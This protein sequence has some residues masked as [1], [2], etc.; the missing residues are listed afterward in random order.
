MNAPSSPT[1]PPH[2]LVP[3][4]RVPYT[5]SGQG[6]II[7]VPLA[8]VQD[9]GFYPGLG[10]ASIL[11]ATA[12]A[13]A[14]VPISVGVEGKLRSAGA[15]LSIGFLVAP[16]AAFARNMRNILRT[17]NIIGLAP[18]Y[19]LLMDLVTGGYGLGGLSKD[20]VA[21]TLGVVGISGIMFWLGTM[22]RAWALPESF[23]KVS[24]FKPTT[25]MLLPIGL[26]SFFLG[27]LAF[28]IP[29]KFDI[30]MMIDNLTTSRWSAAWS[31]GKFGG[32]EA[33]VDHLAY[34]GYLLPTFAVMS[35]RRKGWFNP[36]T[37]LLCACALIFLLFLAQG[38]SRR[39]VGV[40]LGAALSYW[41]LDHTRVTIRQLLLACGVLAFIVVLMQIMVV[42][43]TAG[44]RQLGGLGVA[45]RVAIATIRGE[46][47]D[48]GGAP[49][50]LMVDDNIYRLSQIIH[51]V[52]ERFPFVYW[53]YPYYV[54]VRPIPRFF[55]KGKPEDP[56]FDLGAILSSQSSLTSTILGEL[57][58]VWGFWAL[59][60]GNWLLGRL[61]RLNSPLFNA[62]HGSIAPMLYGYMT[63][64]LFVGY[65]S[66]I[67]IVLFSYPLLGWWAVNNII[68]KVR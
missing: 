15:I 10:I 8:E 32:V 40:C 58:L 17:E 27:M 56:G 55:W 60:P 20:V 18:A 12:V 9:Q 26:M 23:R 65:R 39:I 36:T 31:R 61:S 67:E 24:D 45:T 11:I 59:I 41:V 44:L 49:K 37:I 14:M 35:S 68:N 21:K 6:R 50:S 54:I 48:A 57:W 1:P 19:W 53:K 16:A 25:G 29:C 28:A 5:R 51:L 33:F 62:A 30:G 42:F 4:S 3:G 64:T 47:I 22:G 43:R 34:F 52:P 46:Q 66:M 7:R 13:I 63:M 2:A 38:G